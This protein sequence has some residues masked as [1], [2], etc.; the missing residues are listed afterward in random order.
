MTNK[1]DDPVVVVSN[2]QTP[3]NKTGRTWRNLTAYWILGLCNNYG[4]VVML[5]AA[6]DILAEQTE[7]DGVSAI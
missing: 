2:E 7:S 3:L 4:Y 1:K 6:N 5:T